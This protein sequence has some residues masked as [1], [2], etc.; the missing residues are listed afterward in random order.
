MQGA[1]QKS[2]FNALME[3]GGEGLHIMFISQMLRRD[4]AATIASHGVL[5]ITASD[6]RLEWGDIHHY[7]SLAGVK[8]S[9]E[10][11]QI[12][13]AAPKPGSSQF[14]CSYAHTVKKGQYQI[15]QAL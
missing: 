15:R 11:A 12:L 7:Y 9:P 14:I 1:F 13:H 5:H 8:F 3:H 4:I 2:L 10:Q 6:L